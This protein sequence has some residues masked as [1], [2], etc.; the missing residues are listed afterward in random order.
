MGISWSNVFGRKHSKENSDKMFIHA[1]TSTLGISTRNS[2][3]KRASP[4]KNSS[5]KFSDN[6][7]TSVNSATVREY[8]QTKS[9]KEA[10]NKHS[11]AVSASRKT[12]VAKMK[13]S[14]NYIYNPRTGKV[15]SRKNRHRIMFP[16]LYSR[17][18]GELKPQRTR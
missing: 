4:K 12:R 3:T 6:N 8:E 13:N 9:L 10:A 18:T 16:E 2:S 1:V 15:M 17:K 5:R 7:N 14:N 11:G